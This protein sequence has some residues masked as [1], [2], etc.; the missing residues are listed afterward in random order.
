MILCK[1]KNYFSRLQ[2]VKFYGLKYIQFKR[3]IERLAKQG[4]TTPS[5]SIIFQ[6]SWSCETKNGDH[7]PITL[8]HL[9]KYSNF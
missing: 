3:Q 1:V 7:M 5:Y 9:H 2:N 8:C 4:V 6:L